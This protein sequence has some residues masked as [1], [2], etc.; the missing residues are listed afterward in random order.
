L[1]KPG[2]IGLVIVAVVGL[3]LPGCTTLRLQRSITSQATT[4]ADLHYQQVLNNLA[5][6]SVNPHAI[7]SHVSI[8]DGSAQIQD[9]G[10]AAAT[11]DIAG[12]V[13]TAPGLTGSRSVVEQ[14]GVS[15]V[16]DDVEIRVI[17]V[18]YQRAL[19][20]PVVMDYDTANDLARELG[21]QIAETS[22]V[23]I[24]DEFLTTENFREEFARQYACLKFLE[25]AT[26][27]M[28][29]KR[30]DFYDLAKSEAIVL[31]GKWR[32]EFLSTNDDEIVLRDEE[33]DRDPTLSRMHPEVYR[34]RYFGPSPDVPPRT[35]EEVRREQAESR[36]ATALAR[37]SRRVVKGTQAELLKLNPGW[38]HTGSRHEVPRDA[39]YVGR[40]KDRYAW[41]CADG[42]RGLSEFTIA[43]L[44]FS[45]LIAERSVVT[46]PG[47]PR[48]TPTAKH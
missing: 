2:V 33:Y 17:R 12:S 23:D 1:R 37:S 22:D 42:L 47:G 9:F 26:P 35:I 40:Y 24:R 38:F 16:T 31:D 4:I 28:R 14:W 44:G 48:Y 3:I 34:P 36:Y 18:A 20:W 10:Q 8:R 41:V 6:F 46:V 11:L 19:G 25:Y 13:V 45:G 29:G 15:P 39:C 32:A 5:M 27:E 7:P 30:F 21:K 43:I